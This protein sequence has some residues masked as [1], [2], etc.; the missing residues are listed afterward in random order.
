M[1]SFKQFVFL[2]ISTEINLEF[3]Y[4]EYACSLNISIIEYQA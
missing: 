4:I 1:L 2:V 3:L